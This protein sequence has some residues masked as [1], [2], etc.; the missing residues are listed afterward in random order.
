M[1]KLRLKIFIQYVRY[2]TVIANKES[3][4]SPAP[5]LFFA[6]EILPLQIKI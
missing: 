3:L 1:P 2:I 6:N 5:I 4:K